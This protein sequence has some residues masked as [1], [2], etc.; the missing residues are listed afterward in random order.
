MLQDVVTANRFW[1]P[2]VELLSGQRF[3]GYR[4]KA[5]HWNNLVVNI[6]YFCRI[7]LN[8]MTLIVDSP[9][10]YTSQGVPI[11]VTGIAQV[12]RQGV[13]YSRIKNVSPGENPG[14]ERGNVIGRLRAISWKNRRRDP[15]YRIGD[16]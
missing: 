7:C 14:P 13:I 16:P 2:E 9:T 3:K 15:T 4:G 12:L 10:V 5:I 6:L 11:S 8:T 1:Y